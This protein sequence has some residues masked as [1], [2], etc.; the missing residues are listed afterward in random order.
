[1]P[2]G[3]DDILD[4]LNTEKV[5]CTYGAA[6]GVLGIIPISVGRQLGERRREASWIVSKETGRPTGY[7][8]EQ[9]HQ[10]LSMSRRKPIAEPEKLERLVNEHRRLRG[11]TDTP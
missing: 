5:R 3:L 1:M 4:Y 7:T 10:D 11:R 6:A 2:I 8:P 9:I